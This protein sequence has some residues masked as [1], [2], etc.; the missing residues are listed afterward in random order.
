[1]P[2]EE[3]L[4]EIREN[5]A[6]AEEKLRVWKAE[7]DLAEKAGIVDPSRRERWKEQKARILKIRAAYKV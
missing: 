7:L 6:V 1:M 4:T 5:V 3:Q 2:T